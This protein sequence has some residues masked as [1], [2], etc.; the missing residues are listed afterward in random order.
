MR[1]CTGAAGL[2]RSEQERRDSDYPL[3]LFESMASTI[4]FRIFI[5]S[6]ASF[7]PSFHCIAGSPA[8]ASSLSCQHLPLPPSNSIPTYLPH[9]PS[10][11]TA[12]TKRSSPCQC[13]GG[14]HVMRACGIDACSGIST[15]GPR[16][17]VEAT[18]KAAANPATRAT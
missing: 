9:P 1:R 13:V 7:P 14:I 17:S 15:K 8:P 3:P 4:S 10:N 5:Q 2:L 18:A 12:I 11:P 6:L 16:S